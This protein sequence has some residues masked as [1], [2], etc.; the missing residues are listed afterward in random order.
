M[1][2]AAATVVDVGT[3]YIDGRLVGDVVYEEVVERVAR[4]TPVPGGV[5]PLTNV[6]LV[7]NLL[8]LAEQDRRLDDRVLVLRPSESERRSKR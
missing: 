8:D 6:M 7:R 2:G 1:V 5:G 3:N 4:L